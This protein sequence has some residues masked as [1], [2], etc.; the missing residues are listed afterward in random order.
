MQLDIKNIEIS[1]DNFD[2][3]EV[4]KDFAYRQR[5]VSFLVS[6]FK[7]DVIDMVD[8]EVQGYF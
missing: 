5:K 2:N 4:V 6:V 1:M 7:E 3:R 8:R